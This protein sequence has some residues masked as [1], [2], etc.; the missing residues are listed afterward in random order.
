MIQ[1]YFFLQK[2]LTDSQSQQT[3][4]FAMEWVI[5]NPSSQMRKTGVGLDLP[6]KMWGDEL[7]KIGP[8][9]RFYSFNFTWV[10]LQ[11][12]ITSSL[13]LRLPNW[14]PAVLSAGEYS[15]RTASTTY[16]SQIL[17]I[18]LPWRF[19]PALLFTNIKIDPAA[20]YTV[21]GSVLPASDTRADWYQGA[22]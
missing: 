16:F 19:W 21:D 15:C 4:C 8:A 14:T 10:T 13:F 9:L 17:L 6:L 22:Y 1:H 3:A 11:C 20:R 18:C 7:H 12:K 5:I 2:Q